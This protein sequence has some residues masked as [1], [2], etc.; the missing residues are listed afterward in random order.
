MRKRKKKVAKPPYWPV[1][2]L[3]FMGLR[4]DVVGLPDV[5]KCTWVHLEFHKADASELPQREHGRPSSSQGSVVVL[6]VGE[7]ES[8]RKDHAHIHV[9]Q[10]CGIFSMW[11]AEQEEDAFR[12]WWIWS[13]GG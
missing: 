4:R 3:V 12:V 6:K 11:D 10:F 1:A 8:I 13:F 7:K 9:D 5:D 2:A